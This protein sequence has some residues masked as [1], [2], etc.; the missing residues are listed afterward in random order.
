M[1]TLLI[2]LLMSYCL[3]RMSK[4]KYKRKTGKDLKFRDMFNPQNWDKM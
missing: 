1:A 3:Y 2:L 4:G